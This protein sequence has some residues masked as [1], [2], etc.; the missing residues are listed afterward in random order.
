MIMAEDSSVCTRMDGA[1]I[2][3]N[4]EPYVRVFE[5]RWN[6]FIERE[7]RFFAEIYAQPI[8]GRIGV[9]FYAVTRQNFPG[10]MRVIDDSF[11]ALKEDLPGLAW[12][13]S[14]QWYPVITVLLNMLIII[15]PND[16]QFWGEEQGIEDADD[17]IWIWFDNTMPEE[18]KIKFPLTPE[19]HDDYAQNYY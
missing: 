18:W 19:S 12:S 11:D 16:R 14:Q 13:H 1:D 6:A 8:N 15:K 2:E 9:A 5:Q 7:N 3:K 17:S 4:F 10:R